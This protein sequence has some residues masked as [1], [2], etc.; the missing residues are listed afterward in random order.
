MKPIADPVTDV[1]VIIGRFQVDELHDAHIDLIQ[2]VCDR[3]AKVI[4]FLGLAAL[5]CT[6]ENPLDFE[7][8]KQ[9]MLEKFPETTVL[10]IHNMQFDKEWSKRLDSMI[11]EISGPHQTV[12]LY[13]GRASF[14]DK[15][16]GK[17]KCI[18]LEQTSFVSGSVIRKKI[19]N[20]VKSDAR[21][22][23]GVIWCVMNQFINATPCVDIAILNEDK[24]K[25]LLGKRTNEDGYRF[26]GGHVDAGENYE[27]AAKREVFEETCLDIS[28]LKYV[29]TTVVKCWKHKYE[30]SDITTILYEGK[31]NFGKPEARDDIDELRWFDIKDFQLKSTL[32]EDHIPLMKLLCPFI[33]PEDEL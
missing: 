22:R 7:S 16:T 31:S 32:I 1:G 23:A 19:S 5:K 9:M 13:G 17:F 4:I 3:H 14:I 29:G 15:Y 20:K 28:D 30:K 27:E 26:I 12:S 10:Y 24:S 8:R 25:L 6:F 18:E 11:S 33:K 21:W 2:S